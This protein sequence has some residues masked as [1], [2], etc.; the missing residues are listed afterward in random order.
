[1]HVVEWQ[2]S[3]QYITYRH[4][5]RRATTV[6]TNCDALV[7]LAV[8]SACVHSCGTT[9]TARRAVRLLIVIK[10]K[11][12]RDINMPKHSE[13]R[14]TAEAIDAYAFREFRDIR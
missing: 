9:L 4:V 11:E 7:C 12:T 10:G 5:V 6:H 3:N 1:M 13:M 8:M 2:L 14:V